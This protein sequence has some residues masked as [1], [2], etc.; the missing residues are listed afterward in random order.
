[1][2]DTLVPRRLGD[3]LAWARQ[4][5]APKVWAD[6][7]ELWP[8]AE[9]EFVPGAYRVLL[10]RAAEE[11]ELCH[12]LRFLAE[13]GERAELLQVLA[14]SDEARRRNL[15]TSWLARLASLSSEG[16]WAEVVRLWPQP[17]EPFVRGL[18]ELLLLRPA[19]PRD[20]TACLAFLAKGN[21]RAELVQLLTA[22][23]EFARLRLPTPWLERLPWLTRDGVCHEL[24]RVWGDADGRFVGRLFEV[25][26]R[27]PPGAG[28]LADNVA[29]LRGGGARLDLVRTL[30][31]GDEGR[32]HGHDVSWFEALETS[33][34]EETWSGLLR[35]WREPDL[36]FVQGLYKLLLRRPADPGGLVRHVSALKA[37]RERAAIV[38][39]L[40]SGEEGRRLI[41]GSSWRTWLDS[42][43]GRRVLRAGT[44]ATGRG[45]IGKLLH[46]FPVSSDVRVF[47]RRAYLEIMG[48]QPTPEEFKKQVF[49]LR[50]VPLYTRG[51][52]LRRLLRFRESLRAA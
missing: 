30:A 3:N 52:F 43:R 33:L 36:P 51:F 39:A 23:D 49:R 2:V 32:R 10:G 19:E 17:E 4:T 1:M 15:D 12:W 13:G 37:G 21:A 46:R 44:G 20:L 34:S 16:C 27:R 18:Y 31:L 11:W 7:L 29:L 24:L 8:A 47:V 22:T 41:P 25:I 35:L 28:E 6:V 26:L 48:R 50:F 38:R 42:H 45:E 5:G 14:T 40:A 9:N